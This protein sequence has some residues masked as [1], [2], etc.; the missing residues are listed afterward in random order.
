MK[1][2]SVNPISILIV[3]FLVAGA[4][5]SESGEEFPVVLAAL[6]LVL[7]ITAVVLVIQKAKK[8]K[9]EPPRPE[10]PEDPRMKTFTKPDAPCIV[11]DHTGEDHLERDKR[12]RIRQLDDWLKSGLIDRKEY[13]VLKDRFERDM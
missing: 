3:I 11:C 2:N 10:S 7:V 4:F 9:A 1:K 12:N 6:T 8:A 13:A 5:L